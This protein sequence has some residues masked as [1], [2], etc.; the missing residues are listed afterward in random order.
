M[1]TIANMMYSLAQFEYLPGPATMRRLEETCVRWLRMP[2]KESATAAHMLSNLIWALG[3]LK[4]RPGDD[5]FAVFNDVVARRIDEFNGSGR[6][7]RRVHVRKLGRAPGL[8]RLLETLDAACLRHMDGHLFRRAKPTRSGLGGFS[9]WPS[10]ELA[11]AQAK[12]G[13]ETLAERFF[14]SIRRYIVGPH[15][16]FDGVEFPTAR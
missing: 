11:D 9:A 2:E 6:V 5:F 16:A 3:A 13:D 10:P 12:I 1:Q 7:Q 4:Y 8:A 15:A 14:A